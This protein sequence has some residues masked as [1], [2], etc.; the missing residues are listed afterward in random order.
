MASLSCAK[1]NKIRGPMRRTLP[2]LLIF[3]ALVIP[4]RAQ[5]TQTKVT[6]TIV[7]PNSVP[8]YPAT[9]L[10]CLTPPTTNPTVAGASISTNIGQPYCVGPANTGP[11]GT[12][13]LP[14]YANSVI[15]CS[16]VACT[17]QWQF[18]VTATG[19]APPAGKGAQNFQVVTT[20][21]NLV[22]QDVSS[23]LTAAA[24]VLLNSGGGGGSVGPGTPSNVGCFSSTTNLQNCPDPITDVSGLVTIP[25]QLQVGGGTGAASIALPSG[26]TSGCQT[27]TVGFNILCSDGTNNTIDQSLNGGPYTPI[28]STTLVSPG[29]TGQPV[30]YNSTTSVDNVPLFIAVDAVQGAGI[31]AA[32]VP[33]VTGTTYPLC[34]IVSNSGNYIAVTTA[35]GATTPGT[36]P[37]I[38]YPIP[39]ASRPTQFDCAA[40]MAISQTTSTVAPTIQ[41]GAG[42]Y[43]SCIGV[44][45]PTVSAPGLPLPAIKGVGKKISGINQTC[46]L[47]AGGGGDG[48]AIINVPPATT[49]SFLPNVDFEDFYIDAQNLAVPFDLH[50]C[51]QSRVHHI[52][53]RDP[54]DNQDHAM[55]VGTVGGGQKGWCYELDMQ[56]VTWVYNPSVYP[57]GHG[58]GAFS[59]TVTVTGGVP[60]IT[61][62]NGGLNYDANHLQIRLVKA[63]GLEACTS[64]GTNTPTVNGSGTITA[65]ASTASG[66]ASTGN[67]FVQVY[68]QLNVDYAITFSNMSDSNFIAGLVPGGIGKKC[69]I[70]ISNVTSFNKFYNLH[71]IATFNGVCNQGTNE[72]YSTQLDT[73]YNWGI[74]EEGQGDQ[75]NFYNPKYE[76]AASGLEGAS[77][78][79]LGKATSNPI[80]A[81]ASVNIYTE[82][83]GNVPS[84]D[85]YAHFVMPLGPVDNTS[86]VIPNFFH[87][88]EPQYCNLH[89]TNTIE[90][91]DVANPI[92]WGMGN[93]SNY[94]SWTMATGFS[95]GLT[96]TNVGGTN[97]NPW[98]FT[99]TNSNAATGG[100]NQNS[101][102]FSDQGQYWDGSVT[103]LYGWGVQT[104]FASGTGPLATFAFTKQGTEPAGGHQWTFDGTVSLPTGSVGVTQ[105]AADNT[106]KLATDQFV[107][108]AV[109]AATATAGC[110]TGCNYVVTQGDSPEPGGGNGSTMTS[111]NVG[112]YALFYN[113]LSRKLG[114]ALLRVTTV[115]AAGH[116]DAGIY[117][118]S[119]TTGTLIWHTGSQSTASAAN[120]S[121]SPSAVT[122]N[123]GT[124]YYIAWCADNTSATLMGLTNSGAAGTLM[125]AAPAH[126]FGID[127][128]DGCTAGVLP[129][130]ITTTNIANNSGAS[131]PII[132]GTN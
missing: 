39:N 123:A 110:T 46:T 20:I 8:Y 56:D 38:W 3:L 43:N 15:S 26:A 70:N 37:H 44:N 52:E 97:T 101:P 49:N 34:Q 50:A 118:I 61:I 94:Y 112:Q 14:L 78:F 117:S 93:N 74:D 40:Y 4:A 59:A 27:P 109:A 30:A 1:G 17:T 21:S 13:Q 124:T 84:Q 82:E 2:V 80:N 76:W 129:N 24:P 42:V 72:F 131:I 79:H 104:T 28:A 64:I 105:T 113:A 62:N 9:V 98:P 75:V 69:G 132:L 130:T 5:Q 55:E 47:L 12:F 31:G 41:L 99:L 92:I 128:T 77:D 108:T 107:Q 114:N 63:G 121:V 67:T 126:T 53:I 89:N 111:A 88:H 48:L 103:Q 122:L 51:Q 58:N 127:S 60:A 102:K 35:N 25:A 54:A 66:C 29:V 83:C 71:P 33:W 91:N 73:I 23:V 119:G 19:T 116:F 45:Y 95:A 7:D 65:I 11:D 22:A 87:V 85:G 16:N 36:N 100:G 86:N 120:I 125:A 18:T 6:G 96:L 10:A 106:T 57:M 68:P 81:P 115:G 90:F 32:S